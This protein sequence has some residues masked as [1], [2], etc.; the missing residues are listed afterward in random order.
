MDDEF[1][2]LRSIPTVLWELYFGEKPSI[3]VCDDYRDATG[4]EIALTERSQ[5]KDDSGL[6]KL[7]KRSYRGKTISI[8]PHIKGRDASKRNSFRVHYYV[9][10][11][12]KLIVIGHCGCHLKTSGTRRIV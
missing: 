11:E 10:K 8:V 2:I 4:F 7:R 12:R 3:G 1:I 9:D 6:M 5:T